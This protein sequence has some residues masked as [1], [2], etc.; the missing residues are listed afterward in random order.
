MRLIRW[1]AVAAAVFLGAGAASAQDRDPCGANMVCASDPQTVVAALHKAGYQAK[2][3]A[4]N[5]GDPMI[6]SKANYRF[7]VYFYGCEQKKNCDSLRFEV[8]F[9]KE[10]ENTAAL[11]NKWNAGKRFL[12]MAVK[13]DGRLTVAY[14][15]ATI[16]GVNQRN[17]ADVLD[18]WGAMLEDLNEF[19]EKELPPAPA[20]KPTS[21]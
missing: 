3:S 6:E 12:Y 5:V 13:D 21:K 17:F 15:L 16:G 10:P 7:D 1:A 8:I 9:M 18:W 20:A 14:D 2:L 4:D 11:A 19:F